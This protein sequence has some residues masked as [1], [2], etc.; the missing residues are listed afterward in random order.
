MLSFLLSVIL[1]VFVARVFSILF[2]LLEMTQQGGVLKYEK[3]I[4]FGS[5]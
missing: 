5:R 4:L 3:D 2:L 1:V